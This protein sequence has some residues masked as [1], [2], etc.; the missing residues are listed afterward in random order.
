MRMPAPLLQLTDIRLTFGGAPLFDGVSLAAGARERIALVGRNGSGKSTLRKIA[1]GLVEADSGE[2]FADPGARI[3]YLP[4]EPDFTGFATVGD[5][6]R[7]DLDGEDAGHRAGQLLE[8]LQLNPASSTAILSGGEARRAAL[9][10]I[11]APT[12]DILLLDEP[13]NHLDLPAIA[14]LED[15]LSALRAGVVVISHDRRFLESL[16]TR[17]VWLDRGGS[18]DLDRGFRDFEAWRDK[19]LEEEEAEAH[20]L[21]RKIV[22]EE[23]W[24]RYGVTARRKRNMRR[25]G[26]LEDM[27]RK[28]RETRRAPG[29][30]K[31]STAEG[32]TSG[33]RVLFAENISKSYDGRP[34]ISSFS[35]EVARGDRVGIVGPNGAG[36]TTLLKLLTGAQQPDE[37][38]VEL[39]AGLQMLSLDQR[40]ASLTP[41]M[42]VADAINDGRGDWVEINGQKRH[43]A[44]YLKDFLFAPEQFKA[45]LS[46]LSGGE[47]GRLALAAALARPSNFLVLDEPTNDLDLETLDL[48]EETLA[49]Y[50]GTILLVSH[51]RAFL[52]GVAT[53]I[54]A[55]DGNGRW[56]EYVGGYD[57]MLSQRG[58]APGAAASKPAT[59][60]SA[61]AAP[62]TVPAAKLSFKE[63]FALENLPAQIA[64]L[65][66][67]IAALKSALGDAALFAKDPA[68][69]ARSAA[70]LQE[71]EQA[72]SLAEEEWLALEIKREALEN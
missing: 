44:S 26:L 19:V 41:D 14:W 16:T 58:A 33:K 71:A 61:P 35:I 69:F 72:L 46:A 13:T 53:S 68:A 36:K 42:R 48:L 29:G 52:N 8:A 65:E 17:T 21:D 57:D 39:G 3:A 23:H 37:G 7:A 59:K 2:R 12:P 9:A 54:V 47:R 50:P 38:R 28:A 11:L 63:K 34:L 62:K 66:A 4:Q 15:H 32:Q 64:S 56:I 5:Y 31:F 70:E 30:V 18:R 45:P 60:P 67:R 6:A 43:V 49:D 25:M 10:R 24:V 55:P 1:A 22:A 40:R 27:R 20:K 51:D